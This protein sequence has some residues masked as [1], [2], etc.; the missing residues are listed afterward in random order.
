MTLSLLQQPVQAYEDNSGKPL[1][2]GLLYTYDAGTLT[3]KATYQDADG[4]IPNANPIVLN[5]RG[6]AV[7]YGAGNYRLILKDSGG[8]TIFD[9]DNVNTLNAPGSAGAGDIRV[10]TFISSTLPNP[11]G[12]PTFTPGVTTQLALSRKPGGQYN[13]EVFF[14]SMYQG[15]VG[16]YSINDDKADFV[17]AIPVGVS[18]VDVRIGTTL[19]TFSPAPGSVGTDE[20][21]WGTSLSRTVNSIAELQTLD[22][23]RYQRAF[24]LGYN[25]PGDGG[26]GPYY[27]DGTDTTSASNSGTIIV[28]SDGGRWKYSGQSAATV[29]TFGAKGDGVANDSAAVQAMIGAGINTILFPEGSYLLNTTIALP[30]ARFLSFK[31]TGW[32]TTFVK[33]N[34]AQPIFNYARTDGGGGATMEFEDLYFLYTGTA[35]A[36]GA[37]AIKTYGFND[38]QADSFV[39]VRRC[40]FGA[41]DNAINAKWVGQCVVEGCFFSGQNIDINCFRG[42]SQWELRNVMS[43]SKTFVHVDDAIAD[44]YTNGWTLDDA[45]CVTATAE[46]LFFRNVQKIDIINSGYDLGSGGSAAVWM[47]GCQD[48]TIDNC[49]IS[50]NGVASRDGVRMDACKR[51]DIVGC[52]IYNNLVGVRITGPSPLTYSTAGTVTRCK[53]DGQ[54]STGNDIQTAGNVT[55]NKYF[56][57][58]HAK[59]LNRSGTAFEIYGA[60]AGNDYNQIFHNTFAGSS[61]ANS[62]IDGGANS[63]FGTNLFGLPA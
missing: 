19:S 57:N 28:A 55:G 22:K 17:S 52:S 30:Q 60:L 44:A 36:S 15:A 32:M 42:C 5:A 4:S 2:G 10:D 26:G 41:F 49:F 3:S 12:L 51:F 20:L 6:E 14:D 35:G 34:I 38:A 9:R 16:Q 54:L 47:I 40:R 37:I 45:N 21:A 29:K 56:L 23:A 62:T 53:F 25:F 39:K 33:S 18:M 46:C 43:F 59:Q 61:Y 8:A 13:A 31:G 24:V 1:N 27:M 11:L 63:Q 58:H 7:V 48:V 50:S